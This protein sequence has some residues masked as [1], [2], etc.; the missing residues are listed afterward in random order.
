MMSYRV[1]TFR[2]TDLLFEQIEEML[3]EGKYA[4]K[5]Q[6]ITEAIKEF[7][8]NETKEARKEKEKDLPDLDTFL[9]LKNF[10]FVKSALIGSGNKAT[11]YKNQETDETIQVIKNVDRETFLKDVIRR[12]QGLRG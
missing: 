8:N 2:A 6:L 11:I 1:M 9:K 5:T 4:N 12:S 7:L 10:R 3:K